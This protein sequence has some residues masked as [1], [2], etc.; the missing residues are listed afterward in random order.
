MNAIN[1]KWK[2]NDDETLF[3]TGDIKT[4]KISDYKYKGKQIC[5]RCFKKLAVDGEFCQRCHNIINELDEEL[6]E[7]E[8]KQKK[9][10]EEKKENDEEDEEDD[11]INKIN[12]IDDID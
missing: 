5:M 2:M 4:Y 3:A 1:D 8:E 10:I 7:D 9:K 11:D 12:N 6:E